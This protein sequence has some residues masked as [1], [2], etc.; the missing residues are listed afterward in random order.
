MDFRLLTGHRV[1]ILDGSQSLFGS[2]VKSEEL[3][4]FGIQPFEELDAIVQDAI[5]DTTA[6]GVPLGAIATVD[7]GVVCDVRI[8]RALGRS[9]HDRLLSRMN[10]Q[11]I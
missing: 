2:Q 1:A 7:V 10:A 9:I 8:V 5:R 6:S 4:S 11:I 3:S